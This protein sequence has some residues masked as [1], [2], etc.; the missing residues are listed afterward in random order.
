MEKIIKSFA[1][2][3]VHLALACILG[4]TTLADAQAPT[5]GSFDATFAAGTANIATVAFATIFDRGNA[6][7]LQPDGKIVFAGYCYD[8]NQ[9]APPSDVCIARFNTDGTLD[10]SF[11]GPGGNGNGKFTL[12]IGAA[13]A[14]DGLQ[15][16]RANAV[17]IQ[18]NGKIVIAGQC[19]NGYND[20]FCIA[21]LNSNGSF[22]TSFIGPNIASTG[23]GKVLLTIGAAIPSPFGTT[24]DVATAVLLQPDG[25]IVVSGYCGTKFCVARLNETGSLDASFAGE[26][27]VGQFTLL[28][29]AVAYNHS[30]SVALQSDG[31]I[32]LAGHCDNNTF[33]MHRIN[34]NGSYDTSF[35]IFN[36]YGFTNFDFSAGSLIAGAGAVALQAD[37][38]I[39]VA[40]TC[41]INTSGNFNL[42][43][44]RYGSN[45]KRRD[46]S[47]GPTAN[48]DVPF[49][50]DTFFGSLALQPDGKIVLNGYCL[51]GGF[52]YSVCIARL[53]SEGK[54]DTTFDGNSSNGDGKIVLTGSAFTQSTAMALQQDGKIVLAGVCQASFDS[55]FCL[56]RLNGGPFEAKQ[57]SLDIDGDGLVLATTDVLIHTRIALGIK[58]PAVIGGINFPANAKRKTWPLIRDFLFSQ[59][60]VAVY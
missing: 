49:G 25:K 12:R 44:A 39:V 53:T 10:S 57:C 35:G 2:R 31:K 4:T 7:A 23:A 55:N 13:R 46:A 20:D 29:A 19:S 58:G 5:P 56:T 27:S 45:G 43:I 14:S 50:I 38:Q 16:D 8:A 42:C 21:R 22:D 32:V 9:Y 54:L 40:G 60:G 3:F 18:P 30:V 41:R 48:G 59:C 17:A 33:C 6:V 52:Q 15:Y 47:F 28:S 11:A 37:G 1:R 26:F 24:D 34:G 36:T 51:A